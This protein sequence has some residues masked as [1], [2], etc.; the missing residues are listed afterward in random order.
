MMTVTMGP[1][2][3]ELVERQEK[4]TRELEL[5]ELGRDRAEAE[6]DR[7]LYEGKGVE[8]AQKALEATRGWVDRMER[9]VRVLKAH[10]K[11]AR[12]LDGEAQMEPLAK[13]CRELGE[14]ALEARKEL[15]AAVAQVKDAFHRWDTAREELTAAERKARKLE[16]ATGALA[17]H[18]IRGVV[19]EGGEVDSVLHE[20]IRGVR[21]GRDL[22]ATVLGM[23]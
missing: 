15:A 22:R 5:A 3:A 12:K 13:E 20:V 14:K 4:A 19:P 6:L 2:E 21:V 11:E 23:G 9:R 1:K 7:A 18:M 17:P 8:E 16:K 10:Q